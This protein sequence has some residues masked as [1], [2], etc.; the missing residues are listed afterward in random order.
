MS[1]SLRN[2]YLFAV[3]STPASSMLRLNC[4]VLDED[5]DS[6]RIFPVEVDRNK[7]VGDLKEAI[8][9]KKKRAFDHIDADSLDLWNVSIPVDE[10]T[11]VQSQVKN[12]KVLETKSLLPVQ[13]LFGIFENVVGQYLHVIVRTSTSEYSPDFCLSSSNNMFLCR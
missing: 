13:P 3:V 6:N 2:S 5:S 4:W 1:F 8:K 11:N 12:L 7:N 9:E 10:H